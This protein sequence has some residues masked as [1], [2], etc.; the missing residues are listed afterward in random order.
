MIPGI[1]GLEERGTMIGGPPETWDGRAI[2]RAV[3][4]FAA[5]TLDITTLDDLHDAVGE[6]A[7]WLGFDWFAIVNHVD[8]GRVV[9]SVR[10]TN[11]P[12]EM[13]ALLRENGLMR[14]PVLRASERSSIGFSWDQLKTIA[15][16]REGDDAYMAAC[17]RLGMTMGFTVP[18]NVP[19]EVL[20]SAH[21]AVRDASKLPRA[22]FAAAQSV[23][24]FGFEAARRLV[25]EHEAE[26]MPEP[27][28]LS[29]RQRDC[30]VQV[31]RGK[32]DGVIAEL[33]GLRPRTVNEYVEAAKRRYVVAT[34]QQLVVKAL[35]RSE[36][37][38]SEVLN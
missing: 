18:N 7:R 10:L 4:G 12:V 29:Q 22:H 5:A 36:I 2:Y 11:Y 28:P 21:F 20:G 25:A 15:P 16:V 34:R 38:F 35:F 23:G 14:D 17:A 31:A 27:V 26:P 13:V 6:I 32:S 30:L 19:G 37:S 8:F 3:Q 1:A 24:A 9:P 33:L